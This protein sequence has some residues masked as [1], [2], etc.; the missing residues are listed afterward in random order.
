MVGSWLRITLFELFF[1]LLHNIFQRVPYECFLHLSAFSLL[2]VFFNQF[3]FLPSKFSFWFIILWLWLNYM[4]LW[5]LKN[6]VTRN[7][8][9][10]RRFC[11]ACHWCCHKIFVLFCQ[12]ANEPPYFF[13]PVL[14]QFQQFSSPFLFTPKKKRKK[15]YGQPNIIYC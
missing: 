2:T 7:I 8:L 10:V 13:S 1:L 3:L 14:L 15:L 12:Y 4:S 11:K 6:V 9:T 5:V